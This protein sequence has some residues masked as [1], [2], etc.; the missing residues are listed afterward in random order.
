LQGFGTF[1][2]N[3][4]NQAGLVTPGI[5]NLDSAVSS[6]GTLSISGNYRQGAAG[7]LAIKLD[8]TRDGL[9]HDVLNVT[10]QVLADGS[11]R[12]DL[13]NG[14]S[15]L[16]TASLIGQDFSPFDFGSFAGRFSDVS[17]PT[18]LNFNLNPD[19]SISINPDP[20]IVEIIPDQIIEI[21]LEPEEINRIK[22]LIARQLSD[23]SEKP[24]VRF[25]D[26]VLS[27]RFVDKIKENLPVQDDDPRKRRFARLVCK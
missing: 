1:V 5:A 27:A 22:E 8:S 11:V 21:N 2:G 12:F 19:G 4:D 16:T 13:V 7:T 18:G 6:T 17:I 25:E 23:L 20:D 15:V 10:G 3:V 14:S 26:I 9:L 24:D